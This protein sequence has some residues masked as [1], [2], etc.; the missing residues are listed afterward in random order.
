MDGREYWGAALVAVLMLAVGG[1]VWLAYDVVAPEPAPEPESL[2][3]A[4]QQPAGHGQAVQPAAESPPEPTPAADRRVQP[5]VPGV[6]LLRCEAPSGPEIMP[7]PAPTPLEQ[8]AAEVV[9]EPDA[10]EDAEHGAE[11]ANDLPAPRWPAFDTTPPKRRPRSAPAPPGPKF[12]AGGQPDGAGMTPAP[13]PS[14][15]A[16]ARSPVTVARPPRDLV[17]DAL[18]AL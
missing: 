5:L 14:P 18:G 11:G 15:A 16:G 12:E 1:L 7:Q 9:L 4:W 17:L 6:E 3:P 8:L 13:R 2:P 10:P